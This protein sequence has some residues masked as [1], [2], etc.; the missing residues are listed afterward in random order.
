MS[1][2]VRTIIKKLGSGNAGA[3]RSVINRLSLAIGKT[4]P[5][6]YVEYLRTSDGAAGAP[7]EGEWIIL[8][9]AEEVIDNNKG[10]GV[11]EDFAPGLLLFGTPG[12]E[13]AYGFDTNVRPWRVVAV[14]LISRG[15]EA[16]VAM[17]PTFRE[18]LQRLSRI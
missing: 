16:P 8:W 13:T 5:A 18:F 1:S 3:S 9:S 12:D 17:A 14:S 6:D 4:L 10:Y 2:S 7:K 11:K 15:L